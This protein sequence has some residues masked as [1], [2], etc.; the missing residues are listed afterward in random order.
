MPTTLSDHPRDLARVVFLPSADIPHTT[1]ALQCASCKVD[2]IRDERNMKRV[3]Y[4]L[5][6]TNLKLKAFTCRRHRRSRESIG[7]PLQGHTV[8]EL[9]QLLRGS[10]MMA[11][12]LRCSPQCQRVSLEHDD[13]DYLRTIATPN[14]RTCNAYSGGSSRYPPW[15]SA[16]RAFNIV[17]TRWS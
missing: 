9:R 7:S 14:I 11:R 12:T 8:S 16:N 6:L 13:G 5:S 17:S 2:T 15:P 10:Q 1:A 3:G 4:Q